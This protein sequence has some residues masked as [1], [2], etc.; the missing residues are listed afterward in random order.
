[1]ADAGRNET[2]EERSDRQLGE[3]L[4][5]LRVAQ[6]GVQ[7][8]FAFLLGVPFT[9]RFDVLD[10]TQRA[11]YFATLLLAGLAVALLLGPTVW[12][13]FLFTLRDKHHLVQVSHRFA[14]AGILCVGLD[15]IGV[16]GLI[17]SVLYD[18][19][20]VVAAPAALALVEIVLWVLLPLRR[21]RRDLGRL[22]V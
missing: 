19:A 2:D 20:V 22:R 9:Q 1:M 13:R 8:L 17:A 5:E 12:H 10:S 11:L 4:Q 3:L 7:V 15:V 21:R 14:L 16:V 18:G 6:T